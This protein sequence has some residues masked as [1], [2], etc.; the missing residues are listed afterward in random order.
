[1]NKLFK[2]LIQ[3]QEAI[4]PAEDTSKDD[5]MF[6]AIVSVFYNF[7]SEGSKQKVATHCKR[8]GAWSDC[9]RNMFMK[10]HSPREFFKSI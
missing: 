9:Y 4:A 2:T 6:I 1:M 7:I 5:K 10:I 3:I 8:T